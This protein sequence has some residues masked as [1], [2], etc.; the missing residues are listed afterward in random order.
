M[1]FDKL[2]NRPHTAIAKVVDVIDRT[3]PVLNFNK[4]RDNFK[5]L[6]FTQSPL[7]QRHIQSKPV[8][9]FKQSYFGKIVAVRIEEKIIEKVSRGFNR[10]WIARPQPPVD[11]QDSILGGT[12]TILQ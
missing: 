5:D 10:G 12:D 1:V 11:L 4:I 3:V 8:I 9:Q 7:T 2:A 6:T